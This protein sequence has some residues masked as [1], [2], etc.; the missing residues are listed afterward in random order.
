MKRKEKLEWGMAEEQPRLLDLTQPHLS[1]SFTPLRWEEDTD[2]RPDVFPSSCCF[3]LR[4]VFSKR[5]GR[6]MF[7]ICCTDKV[8]RLYGNMRYHG[9]DE[10]VKIA[11]TDT[12]LTFILKATNISC[13]IFRLAARNQGITVPFFVDIEKYIKLCGGEE[14]CKL[15]T[16]KNFTTFARFKEA[17]D[18]MKSALEESKRNEHI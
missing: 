16:L 11:K 8:F 13:A 17:Q 10:F 7:K 1:V 14:K 4:Y 15:N 9:Y 3:G 2:D 6:K 18:K 5:H 12:M